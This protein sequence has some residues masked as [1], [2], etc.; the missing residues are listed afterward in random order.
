MLKATEINCLFFL[1]GLSF[2]LYTKFDILYVSPLIE[3]PFS[4]NKLFNIMSFTVLYSLN[5][6]LKKFLFQFFNLSIIILM[7][8]LLS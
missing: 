6:F 8:S 3:Y 7:L 4:H 5:D 1:Y 2:S